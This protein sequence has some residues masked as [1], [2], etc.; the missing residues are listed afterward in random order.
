MLFLSPK[1][2]IA[3]TALESML[4]EG[5]AADAFQEIFY[6]MCTACMD[7]CAVSVLQAVNQRAARCV[8]HNSV[9]VPSHSVRVYCAIDVKQTSPAL[10]ARTAHMRR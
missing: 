2:K 8:P 6:S 10:V 3:H 7:A 4:R 5:T 1:Q 9:S